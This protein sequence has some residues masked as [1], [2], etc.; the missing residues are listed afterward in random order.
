[1]GEEDGRRRWEKRMGKEDGRRGWEK[2]MGEESCDSFGAISVT[3]PGKNGD[4]GRFGVELCH[5]SD[6]NCHSSAIPKGL[7]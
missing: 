2:R 5:F 4:F 3:A 1:M 7:A 6:Q